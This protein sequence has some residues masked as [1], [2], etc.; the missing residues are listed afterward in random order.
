[1]KLSKARAPEEIS[2]RVAPVFVNPTKLSV[3]M[4]FSIGLSL[5]AEQPVTTFSRF[6]ASCGIAGADTVASQ[7]GQFVV[8]GVPGQLFAP[9]RKEN[10][11]P[12][13]EAEPQLLAVT[14][15]RTRQAFLKELGQPDGFYNKVHVVVLPRA[16]PEQPIQ[17]VSHVY[18]DGF[19]YQLGVPAFL[20]S[21]RM[22]KGFVQVVL[23]EFAN[24]GSRRNAELPS[25]LVEGMNRQ[26]RSTVFA[27]PVLEQKPLVSAGAF[28]AKPQEKIGFDRLGPTRLF[29]L[30]NA[31]LTIQE[32]S[33]N[34]LPTLSEAERNRYE[35][36]AHLLVNELLA[37][38]GGPV[39]MAAFTQSLPQALNWQTAFYAVYR[40]FFH[41]PL[42]LEK[43]WMLRCV[44]IQNR[45]A[46]QLWNLAFSLERLEALLR[47]P[48]EFR[49]N[50]NSIPEH[51]DATIQ[52]VLEQ[53]DFGVQ[54]DILGQKLQ[55][56]FFISV[57]LSPEVAPLA[58]AYEQAIETY[59]ER[60]ALNDYQPALKSD[61]EQRRELL[62]KATIKSFDQ[63][64]QAR[65]EIRAGRTPKL[66]PMPKPRSA[67]QTLMLSRGNSQK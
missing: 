38:R 47:T 49:A 63:L 4:L 9:A 32:L 5:F 3:A 8:H 37:L 45:Q 67:S 60:R 44:E 35:S 17:L 40:Q 27:T 64:D 42:D 16:R 29:F 15:E 34:N 56:I 25:W 2:G 19:Q 54:K 51:R 39:L 26:L 53:L 66:P 30:T 18:D 61:P 50:T 20:E 31:P 62:V 48:T 6:C 28:L 24:R 7:S 14:G 12:L 65:E 13:I 41:T 1:L 58:S 57:N 36:S 10:E 22:I 43:W 21:S 55:H 59:L 46:H 52:Q 33:F 11:A 23:Q